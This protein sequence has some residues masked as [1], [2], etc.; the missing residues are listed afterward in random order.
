[1]HV[2]SRNLFLFFAKKYVAS[3]LPISCFFMTMNS[4]TAMMCM[5]AS[6]QETQKYFTDECDIFH[7]NEVIIGLYARLPT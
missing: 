7:K 4:T 3:L 1:M 6:G 2:L 5:R